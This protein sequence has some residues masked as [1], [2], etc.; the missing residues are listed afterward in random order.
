MSPI[1]AYHIL[2][3]VAI[4][5]LFCALAAV[6]REVRLLRGIVLREEKGF[7]SARPEITLGPGFA[8]GRTRIV[9]AVDSGCPLCVAATE[10]LGRIAPGAT[11]LTHEDAS[12][13]AG[14]ATG[15]DVV[16][17]R[18]SWRAISH[19]ASPVLMKVDGAG[20]VEELVLPTR[21]S[22]VDDMV[23]EWSADVA[24]A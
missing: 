20:R 15:L 9:L 5:V 2:V 8:D 1:I 13:L 18:D 16:H 21:V 10:R 3:W 17:D 6:M 4:V 22:E 19:L 24:D 12:A 14:L 7:A 11:V 23:T